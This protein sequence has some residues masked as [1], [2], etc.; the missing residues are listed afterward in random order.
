MIKLT[1]LIILVAILC[2]MY[3]AYR[4]YKNLNKARKSL[5]EEVIKGEVLDVWKLKSPSKKNKTTAN[6]KNN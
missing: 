6:K 1:F 5:S 4:D 2:Y 3:K